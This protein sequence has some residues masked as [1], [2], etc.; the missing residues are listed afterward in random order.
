MK[1]ICRFEDC[2]QFGQM[3]AIYVETQGTGV[4]ELSW[5]KKCGRIQNEIG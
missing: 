3:N 5:C 4:F 2:K 1:Q